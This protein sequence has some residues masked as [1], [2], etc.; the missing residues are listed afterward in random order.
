M[1]QT[2]KNGISRKHH[3]ALFG[4]YADRTSRMPRRVKNLQGFS[5][6]VQHIAVLKLSVYFPLVYM[7]IRL[8]HHYRGSEVISY[9]GCT[10]HMVVMMMSEDDAQQAETLLFHIIYK[11]LRLIARVYDIAAAFF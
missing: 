7:G 4:K 2:I 11:F 1:N 3:F 9:F 8:M 5:V 10:S 6:K